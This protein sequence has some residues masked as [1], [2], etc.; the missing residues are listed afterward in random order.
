M[1]TL[2]A[3]CA[4]SRAAVAMLDGG[5]PC[6]R[7]AVGATPIKHFSKETDVFLWLA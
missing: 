7:P 2:G 5:G 1:P 3:G 6:V 4:I